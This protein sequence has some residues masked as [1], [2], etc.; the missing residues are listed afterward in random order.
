MI[1]DTFS[2]I[3]M[4]EK[5]LH[6]SY[7]MLYRNVRNR[8]CQQAEVLPFDFLESQHEGRA[9]YLQRYQQQPMQYICR[10]RYGGTGGVVESHYLV[11]A[12][13]EQV[14]VLR[15]PGQ[16]LARKQP[17]L[18]VF[19]GQTFQPYEGN[20]V[21]YW[22]THIEPAVQ[23]S[24]NVLPGGGKDI[25]PGSFLGMMKKGSQSLRHYHGLLMVI[26]LGFVT[27]SAGIFDIVS[28]AGLV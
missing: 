25:I 27:K 16:A 18:L 12:G 17:F 28:Q 19:D 5:L 7:E 3:T 23:E 2:K 8:L 10:V 26:Y 14:A 4:R 11:V 15:E 13:K 24:G 22:Q 20:A 6:K 9:Y 1:E 21:E